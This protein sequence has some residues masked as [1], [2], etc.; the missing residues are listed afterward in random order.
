MA[1]PSPARIEPL[2]DDEWPK[3]FDNPKIPKFNVIATMAKHHDLFKSWNRFA[4]YI[5]N[6]TEITKREVEILILRTG[7][8]RQSDYEWGQHA[9]IGR[10]IGMTEKELLAIAK[11]P[12]ETTWSA[13]EHNLLVAADE[14][15]ASS[16]IS[17]ATWTA[18]SAD[19]S[20]NQLMDIIMVVGQY[21]LVCMFLKSVRV[22]LDEGVDGLPTL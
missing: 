16:E 22:Q 21:S 19:Y 14:L 2:G 15:F 20:D 18:L 3:E 5:L 9:M 13:K 17:D 6:L 1:I 10:H 11:G 8:N 12:N 4:G 7:W